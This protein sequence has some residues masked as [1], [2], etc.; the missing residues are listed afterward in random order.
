MSS[1]VYCMNHIPAKS[2]PRVLVVEDNFLYAEVVSDFVESH[3]LEAVGPVGDLEEAL[4]YALNADLDGAIL[5]VNL[6]GELCFPI[7]GVL[8]ARHIPFVFLTAYGGT[9]IIPGELRSTPTL[10]KPFEPYRMNDV[11][12]RLVAG[13]GSIRVSSDF[14][15]FV[16]YPYFH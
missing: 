13:E 12:D 9:G 15:R 8:A 4:R 6:H 7:C 1:Y 3:G 5:D 16:R 11:L 2:I 10:S 14:P